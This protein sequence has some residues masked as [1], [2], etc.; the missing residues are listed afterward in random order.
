MFQIGRQYSRRDIFDELGLLPHP[1]G[2]NWFTGYVNHK[3]IFYVFSNVG[4]PGR[5]GHNYG[6]AWE[7]SRLRWYAKTNTHIAQPQIRHL[8]DP[9]TPVHVFWR[10]DNS[11][12]FEYAGMGVPIEVKDT[13][14]VEVL[15]D[16][17]DTRLEYE[18]RDP[19]E[20]PEGIYREGSVR[21]VT[22]NEFERS[23]TARRDCIE[24]Y[25]ARCQVC[26]L[27][28]EDRY[29]EIGIGFIHV[30][31]LVPVGT[32]QSEYEIDPIKDLRPVCPNCHAMIHKTDP[33]LRIDELRILIRD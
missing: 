15:W 16:F 5:T 32:L 28:F 30:H 26:D 25:G 31:H 12:P 11:R 3:D 1:T 21:Q 20:V 19:D 4:S 8:L 9:K 18:Y 2:G 6:N 10:S 24:H 29:G 7:G 23:S 33:P 14:P 27:T 13:T 22:V 17:T